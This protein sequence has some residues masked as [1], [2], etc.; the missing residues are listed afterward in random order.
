MRSLDWSPNLNVSIKGS[1][2]QLKKKA[3]ERENLQG[4]CTL[5]SAASGDALAL[6]T[7]Y[8]E[9]RPHCPEKAPS[10]P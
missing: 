4:Q 5:V 10:P 2:V 8:Q 1:E 3:R 9:G 7:Q 6:G